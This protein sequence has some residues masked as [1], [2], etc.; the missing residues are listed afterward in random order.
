MLRQMV[1]QDPQMLQ[2]LLVQLGQAN[3]QLLQVCVI[4]IFIIQSSNNCIYRNCIMHY[5]YQLHL[6]LFPC[7]PNKLCIIM[8]IFR[9][10]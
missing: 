10:K 4:C 9:S 8:I 6:V 2:S 3:P 7:P 5:I 1:S